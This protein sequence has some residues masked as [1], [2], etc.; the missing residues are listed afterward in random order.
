MKRTQIVIFLGGAA[1][2]VAA[3][4]PWINPVILF[5]E[6]AIEHEG[7]AIGWEGDGFLTGGLGAILLLKLLIYK[8]KPGIIYSLLV[9]ISGLLVCWVILLDFRRIA[10]IGPSSGIL[11]ATDIGLFLTLVG[12]LAM[13]IG[14]L[15]KVRSEATEMNSR[16]NIPG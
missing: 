6:A 5:G 9:T 11:A 4:L 13:I 14:G 2:I 10:A 3:F 16:I 12:G 1:L 8:G 7:I 15:L